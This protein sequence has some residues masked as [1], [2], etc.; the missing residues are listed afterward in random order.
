MMIEIIG[1]VSLVLALWVIT[2]I[3]MTFLI[4]YVIQKTDKKDKKPWDVQ[5]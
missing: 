5:I 2:Y 3:P 1:W 4:A